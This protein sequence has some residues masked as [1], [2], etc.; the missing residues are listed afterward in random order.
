MALIKKLRKAVS[1]FFSLLVV[2]VCF[3]MSFLCVCQMVLVV[4]VLFLKKKMCIVQVNRIVAWLGVLF[5]IDFVF[6]LKFS[7]WVV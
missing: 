6:I 1:V 4:W 3:I 5:M 2:D 7:Y